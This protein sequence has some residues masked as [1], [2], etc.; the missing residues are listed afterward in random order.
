MKTIKSLRKYL[1]LNPFN[2]ENSENISGLRLFHTG[3]LLLAA[4]PSIAF[5]LLII[6]SII[7]SLNRKENYFDD[8][9]NLPFLAASILMFINCIIINIRADF[10]NNQNPSLAWIGLLNWIPFFWF[11]WIFQIYLKNEILRIKAAKYLLI[12]SLPVLF[13]GLSQYFLGWY[14]P[15]EILN[16]LII[17]YQRPLS[18]GGGVT[19]LFNN[20]NYYGAWLSIVLVLVIGLF[21]KGTNNKIFKSINLILICAF[22][23][24]IILSTS[25]NAILAVLG[26]FILLIPFK[27]LKFLLLSFFTALIVLATNL[28]PIV[29]SY[30]KNSLFT[31]VP[32]SLVEKISLNS[33]SEI[34]SFPRVELWLKSVNLIKSNLLMGYGGGSFSD[35]YQ[36]NNGQYEGIQHSHNLILEIAFNYGLPASILI[37][38][39]M[40]LI[41]FKCKNRFILNQKRNSKILR[42]YLLKFDYAW[43]T[44]FIIF[45]F[46]HMFDISYF[47]GRISF[48]AWILLAGIRQIMRENQE[49]Y[50]SNII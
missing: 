19:G 24:M 50:Q 21:I 43:I 48:L 5:L 23:Y 44:S 17:W 34:N 31:L 49:E 28:I 46:L 22:V 39:G 26:T 32:N 47:D 12:G 6:S 4:A 41:L 7:G 8:K 35:L 16:K 30:I 33:V 2:I 40:I 20:Y 37:I 3:I 9:Y 11:F 25:R 42:N 36:L 29:P 38:G 15:Y 45:F 1:T 27:K 13:S 14:G 18:E 10:I